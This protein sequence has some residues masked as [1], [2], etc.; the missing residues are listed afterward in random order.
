[1]IEVNDNLYSICWTDIE[2]GAHVIPKHIDSQVEDFHVTRKV[3]S[4]LYKN[5]ELKLSRSIM[6]ESTIMPTDVKWSAV[7]GTSNRWIV[8]GDKK[9]HVELATLSTKGLVKSS[10]TIKLNHNGYKSEEY[11]TMHSI[12]VAVERRHSCPIVAFGTDSC[13]HL[14]SMIR[15]GQMILVQSIAS[16]SDANVS[17][18]HD[19]FNKTAF[20]VT[21][22]GIEG[23]F[24]MTGY[25]QINM[26][27][28]KFR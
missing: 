17:Y 4:I 13:C 25:T 18:D 5:G 20:S 28:L 6:V 23:G 9:G 27:C 22:T 15:S 21:D 8:A 1:M 16:I 24:I 2:H 11:A 19:Y 14:I 10:L 7:V 12:K 3:M 26:I